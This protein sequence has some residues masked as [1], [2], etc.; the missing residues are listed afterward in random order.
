LRTS[1][2]SRTIARAVNLADGAESEHVRLQANTW[3]AGLE[4]I[5]PVQ[6]TENVHVHQH[7]IPGLTVIREGW[8]AHQSDAPLIDGQV[9]QA[10]KPHAIKMIG[11]PVPHPE[12][13]NV[14]PA[15]PETV[16][17]PGKRKPAGK[18]ARGAK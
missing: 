3:I 14:R 8:S 5:A 11:T 12:A 10:G 16:D 4:S 6:R 13:G 2:A 17:M 1:E 18:A 15:V 9:R 7:L